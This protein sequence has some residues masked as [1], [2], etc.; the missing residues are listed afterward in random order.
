MAV[1]QYIGA[2]YVP[3]FDGEWN[4]QKVY[5]P[6]TIV[7]YNNSSYTSKKPVP[8]GIVP[9]DTEYWALSGTTSGQILDLQNRVGLLENETTSLENNVD[10]I[11]KKSS[12]M[13]NRKFLLI[14]DSYSLAGQTYTPWTRLFADYTGADCTILADNGGGF[15]AIGQ[16]GTFEEVLVNQPIIDDITDI[17]VCGGANDN[18]AHHPYATPEVVKLAVKHFIE[19]ARNMYEKATIYI[20]FIGNSTTQ[21]YFTPLKRA[22]KSY[23]SACLEMGCNFIDGYSAIITSDLMG[24]YLHPT[25]EGMRHIVN[26]II[27]TINGNTMIDEHAVTITF[28][29]NSAIH[30]N[31]SVSNAMIEKH[32]NI[33]K[34]HVLERIQFNFDNQTQ[35]A[36]NWIELADLTPF[37]CTDD[38]IDANII[39]Q[40]RE[41]S[42]IKDI[43]MSARILS[44]K[45]YIRPI[46]PVT[47]LN[48]FSIQ[49]VEFTDIL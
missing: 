48:I 36:P 16:L 28:T 31:V 37:I 44:G 18:T 2:R 39:C 41:G 15:S 8:T 43:G 3:K 13:N 32:N 11:E 34:I 42:T 33:V 4:S 23:E 46:S 6:L 35:S 14:G 29:G 40:I 30:C 12:D 38:R 1:R 17:I 20:G 27:N 26:Y 45:L 5:E 10:F 21:S 7:E 47:D 25:T 49:H 22:Y 24:D 9:T 19:T